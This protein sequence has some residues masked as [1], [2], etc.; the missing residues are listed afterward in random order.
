M[1]ESLTG[2]TGQRI[3]A[4]TTIFWMLST[5]DL[6][7]DDIR[8]W[9]ILVLILILD[10]VNRLDGELQGVNNIL[11]MRRAKLIRLKDFI[12]SVGE[13]NVHSMDELDTILKK[14]DTKDE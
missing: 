12:D 3:V 11:G 4:T 14:E 8:W 5:L 10:H 2:R 1:W 6:Y 9:S 13:G 7:W